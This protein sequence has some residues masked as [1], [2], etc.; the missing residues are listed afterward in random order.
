MCSVV[1][2]NVILPTLPL[3]S[4]LVSIIVLLHVVVVVCMILRSVENIIGLFIGWSVNAHST[5]HSSAAIS[6]SE[7][8]AASHATAVHP[9]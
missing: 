7:I 8:V 6:S 1:L 9:T 4:L 3:R 2:L 5:T